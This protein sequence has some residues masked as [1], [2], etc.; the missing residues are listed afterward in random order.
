MEPNKKLKE[1]YQN[2]FSYAA[3]HGASPDFWEK[4]TSAFYKLTDIVN[5]HTFTVEAVEKY[6]ELQRSFT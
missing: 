3:A 6:M 5:D 1:L 4:T 2:C